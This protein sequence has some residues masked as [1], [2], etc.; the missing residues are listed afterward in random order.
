M[1]K[2]T[3]DD[4]ES[5]AIGA[6]IL[7]TGGGGNPYLGKLRMQQLLRQGYNAQVIS[8]DELADDAL[9]CEVGWMGAPTVGVEKLPNGGESIHV[10]NALE[11]YIGKTIDAIACSEVG[12]SNSI[13]PL[14]AGALTGK[15]VVDGDAMGRAFPEMQMSTLFIDG[16]SCNPAA[17]VDE[18][19]NCIV[20]DHLVD[21]FALEKF[22]RD[23]C[24]QMGCTSLLALGVIS[25]TQ[26]KRSSVRA[27][28]S[29]VKQIGDAVRHARAVKSSFTE[30]IL[31]VTGGS[32]I[33]TGKLVDVQRRTVGGFAR[34]ELLAEG[35]GSYRGD[36]MH[37]AFQ[38][39]NLV[40]WRGDRDKHGEVVACVPDL[41][42]MI[43]SET[44][45]PITTEQLRYG[46]R[47]TV[48]GIPCTDKFRTP[49]ALKV[50][51][52]AAFGYPEVTFIPMPKT[53]SQG[54]E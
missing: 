45:E 43:E 35:L 47:V 5:I 53:P 21:S 26:I 40:A 46:L 22:G 16:V 3:F 38:N 14:E 51:G 17:M 20:F 44:G 32:E 6:G 7:G 50:V 24:V 29:L 25:G 34:G 1:W 54:I 8:L 23:L 37:I 12:G 19:G 2:I 28:L 41:I 42:C 36:W 31:N 49:Q 4:V 52:P 18:K 39:E 11:K 33:F 13:A 10:I 48:L 15:P 30:A 27:T 9:V